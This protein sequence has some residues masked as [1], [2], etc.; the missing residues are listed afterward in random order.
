M[1]VLYVQNPTGADKVWYLN[2]DLQIEKPVTIQDALPTELGKWGVRD[3]Y[4][5]QI[6]NKRITV[7]GKNFSLAE[8]ADWEAL[9][10]KP[11]DQ[12]TVV[13]VTGESYTGDLVSFGRTNTRGSML[14]DARMTIDLEIPDPSTLDY[15]NATEEP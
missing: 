1:P 13:F 10:Q 14:F 6:P 5:D 8:L 4:Y 12:V 9:S 2:G 3:R 11:L 15:N 7:E